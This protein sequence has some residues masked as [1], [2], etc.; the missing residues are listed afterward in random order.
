[1]VQKL[2]QGKRTIFDAAISF[3]KYILPN[4]ALLFG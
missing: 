1:L 4:L 2:L 3:L